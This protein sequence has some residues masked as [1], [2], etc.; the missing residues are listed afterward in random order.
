MA[1]NYDSR[2][3][4]CS[5]VGRASLSI[6]NCRSRIA[7]THSWPARCD[8]KKMPFSHLAGNY[9]SNN[10]STHVADCLSLQLSVCLP[11]CVCSSVCQLSHV[12]AWFVYAF[13][14]QLKFFEDF[15]Y[16]L[17]KNLTACHSCWQQQPATASASRWVSTLLAMPRA[18]RR[19]SVSC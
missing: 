2:G 4:C 10:K 14:S 18:L 11:V 8:D 15:C 3:Y 17:A 9:N 5:K 12:Y 16:L 7:H 1:K 19:N 6:N 13:I